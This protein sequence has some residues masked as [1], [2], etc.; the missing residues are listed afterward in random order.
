MDETAW[1]LFAVVILA[2]ACVTKFVG[3]GLGALRLGWAD[4]ARVG[5]GMIPRGEVGMV[6]AQIGLGLRI[7]R[8][9]VELHGGWIGH[10]PTPGG[11]ATFWFEL[12]VAAA[13][14]S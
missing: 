3:C 1:D 6:V 8:A 11:G 13:P 12:P 7:A 4:A 5:T 2:V 10:E 14:A 9:L